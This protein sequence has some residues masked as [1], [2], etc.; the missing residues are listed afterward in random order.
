MDIVDPHTVRFVLSKPW[1]LLPAMLPFQEIVS[2][3]F[4]EKVGDDGMVT[5]EDGTGPF[6]LVEWRRGDCIVMERVAGLLR[7]LA[8]HSAGRSGAGGSG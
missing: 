7:R 4:V 6:R 5:Q 1:P 2:K 3:A 8:G